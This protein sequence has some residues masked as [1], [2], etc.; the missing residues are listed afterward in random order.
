MQPSTDWTRIL[1]T[2]DLSKQASRAVE[3]AHTLAEKFGSELHVLHVV[4][5]VQ[6]LAAEASVH[7]VYLA[8]IFRR[9]FGMSVV[10]YIKSVRLA[11]SIDLMVDRPGSL[12]LVATSSGFSDQAHWCRVFKART[13]LT[14]RTFHQV[15]RMKSVTDSS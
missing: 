5:D 7:P 10:E 6:Q 13:G 1:V 3:Y 4:D 9:Y 14:P 15:L 2:T 8:R 11:Q 12:G